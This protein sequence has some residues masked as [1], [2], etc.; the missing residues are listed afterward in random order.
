MGCFSWM[1]ANYDNKRRL[2][3]GKQGYLYCPDGTV[4][5]EPCY[6]GDGRFA[7]QDVY[8][9]VADWNRKY[10]A[11][12]PDFIIAQYGSRRGD[13]GEFYKIPDMKVSDFPWY[14]AYADLSKTRDEVAKETEFGDYRGIGIDIACYDGQ[15][16][17]LPF[18]IKICSRGGLKYDE[19]PPSKS[20]PGQ[21]F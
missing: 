17:N 1:Y 7:G 12:H 5:R 3:M 16:A 10:L 9:L 13:D 2:R 6:D 19:L 8:D 4:L 14:V 18:P 20:D 21:G 15:N 11:A